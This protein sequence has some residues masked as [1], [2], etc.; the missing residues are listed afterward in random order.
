V[1]YGQRE[2]RCEGSQKD[3]YGRPLVRCWIGDLDLGR[4]MVRLG[5]AVAEYGTEYRTDEEAAQKARVG[6]WTGTFDRPKDWRRSNRQP[7]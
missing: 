2:V 6:A 7:N 1:L 5:W 3:R 4:E